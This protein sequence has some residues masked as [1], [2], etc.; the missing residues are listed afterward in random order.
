MRTEQRAE[1]LRLCLKLESS[2]VLH[3]LMHPGLSS[4]KAEKGR[5][6]PVR[7]MDS[8]RET[9]MERKRCEE[10]RTDTLA[11]CHK[12]PH[13]HSLQG[14]CDG[15]YCNTASGPRSFNSLWSWIRFPAAAPAPYVGG[16]ALG[17]RWVLKKM[18]E[19][20][21]QVPVVTLLQVSTNTLNFDKAVEHK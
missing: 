9:R 4:E 19:G 15:D 14:Y 11:A 10:Q 20:L 3:S 16:E 5:R 6:Q 17:K 18:E 1:F 21:K 8:E 13:S 12:H 2:M 7:G